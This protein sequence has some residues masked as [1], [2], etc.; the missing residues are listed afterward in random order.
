ML[1]AEPLPEPHVPTRQ[2]W[3]GDRPPVPM[4]AGA[5]PRPINQHQLWADCVWHAGAPRSADLEKIEQWIARAAAATKAMEAIDDATQQLQAAEAAAEEEG[6]APMT[7][8]RRQAA[9]KQLR[10]RRAA[11]PRPDPPLE[12]LH[13]PQQRLAAWARGVV[14]NCDNPEDC[15][16]EQPSTAADPPQSG[17]N[18]AFFREWAAA[19][20]WPDEDMI[21]QVASGIDS[22][23]R[24]DLTTVLRFH[25]KGLQHNFAPARA[26]V[27]ADA[28]PERGWI[29]RGRPHLPY[30]P[31]R[32]VAKN[33]AEQRKW[34]L[35]GGE[36]VKVVKHRVTTDDSMEEE[37]ADSRN[38]SLPREDW[39]DVN[40]P[41]VHTLARAVAILKAVMPQ[42]EA[43]RHVAL[44]LEAG[45]GLENIVLWAFDMSNAYRQ[46]AVQRLERW[47]QLF[48]WSDGCRV[49]CRC[50]FGTAHMVQL[51]ER[52]STFLLAVVAWRQRRFDE[53]RPYSA[54]RRAW[55]ARRGSTE[56]SF[57]MIYIDD[58]MGATVH[59][60]GEPLRRRTDRTGVVVDPEAEETRAEA[61]LRIAMETSKEAGWPVQ[62]DK[63]QLDYLIDVLGFLV[64]ALGDGRVACTPAKRAGLEVELAALQDSARPEVPAH[65]VEATAG[66]LIHLAE[67]LVEGRAHMEPFYAMLRATRRQIIRGVERRVRPGML[68]VVG[69]GATQLR[70][71][72]SIAWWRAALAADACVPLAPR[73]SFPAAGSEGCALTFSD[74]AREDG[75]GL[76]GY[77]PIV[78]GGEKR[79]PLVAAQ[80]PE[81]LLRMLQSNELSM[82]AGELFAL[83]AIVTAVVH[84]VGGVSHAIAMTDS[85]ATAEAVNSGASGSAQMQA[86]LLWLSELCPGVRAARGSNPTR[87]LGWRE[88]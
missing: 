48:V 41:R 39:P 65:D 63:V 54:A 72:R 43:A 40:L 58:G 82:P 69:T 10:V 35:R 70:L 85:S 87:R 25:H 27:E 83:V 42:H 74:A 23:A 51:F 59:E 80:W 17:I 75:T 32:L 44:A 49:D 28:A 13:F 21:E 19:L 11:L 60:P 12:V 24:C 73:L 8:A 3:P 31:A 78:C 67:V 5:P 52:V 61:H 20:Q 29:W 56:A 14:W 38:S 68:A 55:L 34:K 36:A 22:R 81:D 46:L 71:S 66:K 47:L 86:L 53:G 9:A 88:G 45:V 62:H 79:L 84:H 64:D 6:L 37:G 33:V 4:P 76:G 77:A 7:K 18:V 16:P 26:S 50:A 1:A 30:V 2:A 57:R 15:V